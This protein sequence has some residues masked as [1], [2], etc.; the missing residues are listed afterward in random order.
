LLLKFTVKLQ[1]FEAADLKP[2]GCFYLLLKRAKCVY[3]DMW[4]WFTFWKSI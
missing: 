3:W 4:Y 1:S 2:K